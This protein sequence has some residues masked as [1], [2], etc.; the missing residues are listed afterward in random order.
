M[1]HQILRPFIVKVSVLGYF[2]QVVSCTMYMCLYAVYTTVYTYIYIYIYI[3]IY[4]VIH[5]SVYRINIEY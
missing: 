4:Y 1:S 3:Y 5:I 2:H